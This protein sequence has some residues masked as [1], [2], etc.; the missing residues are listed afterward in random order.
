MGQTFQAE[1]W[2]EITDVKEM[3]RVNA[4]TGGAVGWV[5]HSRYKTLTLCHVC[6]I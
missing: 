5:G 2:V 4:F 3:V 6:A 1:W